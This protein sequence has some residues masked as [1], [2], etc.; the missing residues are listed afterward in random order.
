MAKAQH[1]IAD[2]VLLDSLNG[3]FSLAQRT[4]D[5]APLKAYLRERMPLIAPVVLLMAIISICCAASMVMFLGGTNSLLVLLSMLLAP[6]VLVGSFFVQAYVFFSWLEAR[7]L[8]KALHHGTGPLP[9]P[10]A[11]AVIFLLLP[12]AMLVAVAPLVGI[13]LFVL[14]VAAPFGFARLDR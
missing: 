13:T 2:V 10:W 11:L 8:A 12:L 7:A 3:A 5:A 6:F 9:V 14:L 4:R 1:S